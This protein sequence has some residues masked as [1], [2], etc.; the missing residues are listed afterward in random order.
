[1]VSRT[2]FAL[3]GA[4]LSILGR[5]LQ[6]S[7]ASASLRVF[8]AH[9]RRLPECPPVSRLRTLDPRLVY[10]ARLSLRHD[11]PHPGCSGSVSGPL[12]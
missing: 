7:S 1:M 8:G 5:M 3:P 6:G 2:L 12:L 10:T 9:A 11:F 4:Y